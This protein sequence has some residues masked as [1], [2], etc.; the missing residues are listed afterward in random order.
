MKTIATALLLIVLGTVVAF[1]DIGTLPQDNNSHDVQAASPNGLYSA[2]LTVVS[3]TYD[4]TQFLYWELY[5]PS[6]DT[7]KYRIMPTSAK[8]A[9]PQLSIPS[10]TVK[11]YIKNKATPFVNISGCTLGEWQIE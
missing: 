9:Y 3:Y 5:N 2:I 1:A 10:G 7:C 6:G 11:G 8:G 4:M